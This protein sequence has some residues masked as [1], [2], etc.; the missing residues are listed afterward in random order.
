MLDSQAGNKTFPGWEII[1]RYK[2]T[3]VTFPAV[4]HSASKV[5]GRVIYTLFSACQWYLSIRHFINIFFFH[6]PQISQTLIIYW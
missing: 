5:M 3:A 6:L 1:V 4:R 2:L